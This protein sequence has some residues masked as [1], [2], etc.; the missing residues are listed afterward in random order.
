VNLAGENIASGRWTPDKKMEIRDSRVKSTLLLSD[1]IAKMKTPPKG[2]VSGSAIGYY[3]NRTEPVKESSSPGNGFLADV[4][5]D[6]EE[7]TKAAEKAGV[8]VVHLRIGVVLD[9]EGGALKRMLLPFKLGLG[10]RLGS[11]KQMMSWITREDLCRAILYCLEE[12]GVKGAVNATAPKPVSNQVFTKDLGAAL[13]RPTVFP[14][15]AF[16]LKLLLGEMANEMLLSGAAV[17]PEKLLQKGFSFH[18][19]ELQEA[20]KSLLSR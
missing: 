5:I 14:V 20:L 13:G 15:P 4:C 19:P 7:A 17:L 12:G 9:P 3:G 10:G 18:H 8:R 16:A 1:A 6:W 11:G 2:F